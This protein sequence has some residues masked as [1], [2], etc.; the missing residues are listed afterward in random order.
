MEAGLQLKRR[1]KLRVL[2]ICTHNSARSQMAEAWLNHICG[3]LFEAHSAGTEPATVNPLAI[4]VMGEAGINIPP[5][6]KTQNVFD[7]YRSGKTFSYVISVCD[8]TR[9]EK[10]PIYPGIIHRLDWSFKDPSTFVG[11]GD[12]KLNHFREARDAIRAK[13]ELWCEEVCPTAKAT[14]S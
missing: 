6:K 10:S 12:E 9:Q 13:I 1:M 4:Q 14:Y 3:N 5:S 8:Q 7:L 11:T 2:F